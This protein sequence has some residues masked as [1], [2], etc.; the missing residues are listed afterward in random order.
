MTTLDLTVKD[1]NQKK[2][3]YI[4]AFEDSFD[5]Y[6]ALFAQ[7]KDEGLFIQADPLRHPLIFYLAHTSVFYVNKFITA[8]LIKV[9]ERINPTFESKFAV[10]VDEMS[11]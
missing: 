3:Q 10:G 6:E 9:N 4:K 5:L 7:V 11:W 2:E 1:A 8:G